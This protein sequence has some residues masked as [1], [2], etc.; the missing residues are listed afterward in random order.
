MSDRAKA[1]PGQEKW[2]QL[3]PEEEKELK[4][5]GAVIHES[6]EAAPGMMKIDL[7]CHTE[8]SY[9]CTTPLDAILERCRE[10]EVAV[11]A[12]TDHNE[13]WGALELQALL[14]VQRN[15]G[16]SE[17]AELTLIVGEEI[18]TSEGEII[19][20]FL[21]EKIEAGMTP[22]ETVRQ[23]K[24]QGGLVLLPHGFDPLKRWRLKPEARQRIAGAIDVVETFNARISRP[25]W[26]RAGVT[27]AEERG[28]CLS[29]GSDAHTLSDI[30]TA[31]VEVIRQRVTAP[32]ELLAAL[33]G[34]TPVGRWTHPAIA[35][36]YKMWDQTRRQVARNL[37]WQ[38]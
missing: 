5:V 7:H 24:A 17:P 22:E 37:G 1:P 25:R 18:T 36:G 20:L 26:N 2:P 21:T 6:G 8:A 10:Q 38:S 34:G 16:N 19:G 33:K 13:I 15:G 32:A 31:W 12:I 27:W 11:Q 3:H 9:D 35:F 23:I 28:L 30:G 29:A 4:S 14:A